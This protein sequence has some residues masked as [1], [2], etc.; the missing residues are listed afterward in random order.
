MEE[1]WHPIIAGSGV[2]SRSGAGNVPM[3]PDH[4]IGDRQ[5]LTASAKLSLTIHSMCNF[6]C[7]RENCS[8]DVDNVQTIVH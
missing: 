5:S 8:W 6:S 2:G 4:T 1:G 7:H 3:W